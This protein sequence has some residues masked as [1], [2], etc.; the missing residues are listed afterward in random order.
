MDPIIWIDL[1]WQY[2]IRDVGFSQSFNSPMLSW[3]GAGGL[4]LLFF[5]HAGAL[6][7]AA[8]RIRRAFHRVCPAVARLLH[9]RQTANR[10]WI[11]IPSLA[12]KHAPLGQA[13]G[14]R[15]D[16]DDLQN[17][18]RTLR[19]EPLFS[20]EWVSFRKSFSVEQTS[21]FIEPTVHTKRSAAEFFSLEGICAAS[22]NLRFYQQLPSIITGIGLTFTFLAILVGLSKLHA[23]GTQIEG[24]QGLI[25][26]LAGKFL[27]SIVGL[28]CANC[29]NVL[30][31]SLSFRL[32]VYFR[33]LVSMLDDMF[34]QHVHDHGAQAAA[35]AA[36]PVLNA[37]TPS[38][39]D[40]IGRLAETLSQRMNATVHALTAV[41]D[42]LTS[43]GPARGALD[44]GELARTLGASLQKELAPLL[45][46]LREAIAE[47]SRNISSAPRPPQLSP[48]DMEG[49]VETLKKRLA[50]AP[51]PPRENASSGPAV[52]RWSWMFPPSKKQHPNEALV[53]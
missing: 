36:P 10:N 39:N 32:S 8:L 3:L 17:L 27:T 9:E 5:W 15:R 46:P 35:Q 26:G 40:S 23:D 25:N 50:N 30:D 13:Q 1:L 31:K 53:E 29:F 45:T 42:S 20:A 48:P 22:M 12:K 43:L 18:D 41:S 37:S 51:E 6:I 11:V 49:V 2:L 28:A 19:A 52:G 4:L 47:L 33:Q 34:P 44:Q 7:I 24:M 14:S 21:W 38:R 16:L